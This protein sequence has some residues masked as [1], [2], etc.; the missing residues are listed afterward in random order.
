MI[1]VAVVEYTVVRCD[2]A[3]VICIQNLWRTWG[4]IALG[5]GAGRLLSV[6]S[7]LEVLYILVKLSD[8][9]LSEYL[10]IVEC[11]YTIAYEQALGS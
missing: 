2:V 6:V 9:P 3:I 8:T 5:A 1:R 4:T 11:V 7:C 10:V